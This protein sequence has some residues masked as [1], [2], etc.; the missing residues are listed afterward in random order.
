MPWRITGRVKIISDGEFRYKG[1]A[2][3]G[4]LV[5]MGKCVVLTTGKISLLIA[6]RSGPTTDPELYRSHGIEPK[7]MKLVLVKSPLGARLEY[8]PISKVFISVT[9]PGCC[10]PDLRTLPFE[11][12]PHPIFPFDPVE[13]SP[14]AVTAGE[15]PSIGGPR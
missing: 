8:E 13:F 10:S 1:R 12:M 7:D 4:R 14:V 11:R 3:T 2:Y 15:R 9:S 5:K 6:E